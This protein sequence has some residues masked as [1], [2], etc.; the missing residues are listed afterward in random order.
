MK[1][2]IVNILTIWQLDVDYVFFLLAGVW[3]KRRR[4]RR[5]IKEKSNILGEKIIPTPDWDGI[6]IFLFQ[7]F[8]GNITSTLKMSLYI[9]CLLWIIHKLDPQRKNHKKNSGSNISIGV[10]TYKWL[11][12]FTYYYPIIQLQKLALIWCKN[13][14]FIFF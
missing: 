4:Q 2:N 10:Y 1:K 6:F 8:V 9:F 11:N 13:H 12:I 14:L 7:T 5:K 3:H